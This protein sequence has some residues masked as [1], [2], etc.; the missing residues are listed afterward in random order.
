MNL[1]CIDID[2]PKQHGLTLYK[3]YKAINDKLSI[4]S[5]G[6]EIKNDKG[7]IIFYR[8][9]RFIELREYNLS[10]ILHDES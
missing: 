1:I 10:K 3:K 6:Y 2:N 8:I 7:D 9:N 5:N 4:S